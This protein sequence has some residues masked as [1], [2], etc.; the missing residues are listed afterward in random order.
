[1]PSSRALLISAL[2]LAVAGGLAVALE[3]PAK[4]AASAQPA[5]TAKAASGL[6]DPIKALAGEWEMTD[7]DGKTHLAAVYRVIA[8][9]S[10]VCETMFPGSEHEMVNM[11]HL[12]GPDTLVIT[13][14]CAVGNQPRMTGK[15]P[16]TPGTY[17]F[18]VKDPMKDVTNLSSP[19]G[20]YMG[21]LTL[22]IK[23]QNHVVQEW[24]HTDKGKEGGKVSFDLVRRAAAK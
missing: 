7:D 8:G 3:P 20:M 5:Q 24:V 15:A 12:D 6:L 11:Y 21:Q 14:Y 18:K 23:D 9:G 2:A 13:H 19:D 4:D 10:T 17:E 22:I 1:M 16:K